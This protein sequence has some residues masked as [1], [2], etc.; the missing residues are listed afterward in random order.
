MTALIRQSSLALLLLISLGTNGALAVP[1][2][3]NVRVFCG[4]RGWLPL[5]V[6]GIKLP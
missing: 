3:G 6:G 5:A 2:S 1:A 4:E